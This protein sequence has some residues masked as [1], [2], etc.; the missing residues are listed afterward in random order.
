[1]T[2]V[3]MTLDRLSRLGWTWAAVAQAM[4]LSQSTITK[5][6]GGFRRPP[7]RYHAQIL[8]ELA[9]LEQGMPPRP[10]KRRQRTDADAPA[11]LVRA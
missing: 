11:N 5:W 10:Y 9:A 1:M 6:W 7:A 2:D 3:Q 4:G 8:A